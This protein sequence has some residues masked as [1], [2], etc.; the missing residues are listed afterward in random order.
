MLVLGG[1]GLVGLEWG[2]DQVAYKFLAK[3]KIL[4]IIQDL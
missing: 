3:S 2:L 4:L 1:C